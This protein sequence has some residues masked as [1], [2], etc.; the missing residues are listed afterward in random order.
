LVVIASREGPDRALVI[1]LKGKCW[2]GRGGLLEVDT[3]I[4]RVQSKVERGG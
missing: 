1:G 4:A 2:Y 3:D